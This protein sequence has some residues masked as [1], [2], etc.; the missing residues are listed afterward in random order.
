MRKKIKK[1]NLFVNFP[2][3]ALLKK[4]IVNRKIYRRIFQCSE[5]KNYFL[6]LRNITLSLENWNFS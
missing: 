2:L 1:I 6:F 5:R 4:D 3:F